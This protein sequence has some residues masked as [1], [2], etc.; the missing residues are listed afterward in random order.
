M[1]KNIRP[2]PEAQTIEKEAIPAAHAFK[3]DVLIAVGGGSTMDT[4]KGVA[5][6]GETDAHVMDFNGW[7]PSKSLPHKTYPLIAVPSTAGT[8]SEVCRNAVI[9]DEK[10]FQTGSYA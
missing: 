9:C 5:I 1:F 6:V 7:P 8:G 4:A 3:A 2:N 10:R